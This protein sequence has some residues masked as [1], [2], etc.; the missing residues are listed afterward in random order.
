M[1]A[2]LLRYCDTLFIRSL[3]ESTGLVSATLRLDWSLDK[4]RVLGQVEWLTIPALGYNISCPKSRG[5]STKYLPPKNGTIQSTPNPNNKLGH[6]H[7]QA[8]AT[9]HSKTQAL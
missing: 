8:P 5:T 9:D 1:C 6:L 4:S 2:S 7:N 3:L